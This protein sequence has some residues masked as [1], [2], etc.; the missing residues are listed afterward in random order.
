MIQLGKR[1]RFAPEPLDGLGVHQVGIED[2]DRDLTIE[3]LVDRLVDG[4]HTAPAERLD[5][6][7]FA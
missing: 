7:V 3:R 2:L 6:V 4:P 1:D 5:D